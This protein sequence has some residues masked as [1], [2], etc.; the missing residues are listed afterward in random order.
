MLPDDAKVISVDDHIIEPPQLW[1]DRV[2]P[3]YGDAIPQVVRQEKGDYWRYD[4][5]FVHLSR[6]AVVAGTDPED[7]EEGVTTFE[8]ARPGTW[9]VQERLKDMDA[10]G[11]WGSVCFPNYPRFAGHHFLIG[12]D[13]ELALE[14]V[15]AWNDYV[16][17]EWCAAAPDRFIPL[18]IVPLW[19]VDLCVAEIQRVAAKGSRAVAFSEDPAMLGL[20]SIWTGY[21]DPFVAAVQDA[22]MCL[23]M[24]IGSSSKLIKRDLMAPTPDAAWASLNSV[25]S[26]CSSADWIFS[27]ILQKHPNLRIAFS[28]GGAGWAPHI[29]ERM[30]L[31]WS[32]R[33]FYSGVDIDTK[34]SDLFRKHVGLCFL[35]DDVA[36]KLRHDIGIETLMFE[37]DYPHAESV[38]P[39]SRKFLAESLVDVPDDEA[40]MIV[41]GNARR[42]FRFPA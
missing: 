30:D 19:D 4:G 1:L 38:F 12:D 5:K 34:P 7:W 14:C 35:K 25:N 40:R 31:V 29:T 24:H 8:A 13:R 11:V 41:E 23:C 20:P 6:L 3:K 42:W 17:D 22:D 37:S 21:W 2:S 16:I 28:E 18:S 36:I 10:D 9:Q 15:Q 26:M 33:K 27:G 32:F 39:Y